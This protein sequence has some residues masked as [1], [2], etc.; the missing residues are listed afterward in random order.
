MNSG[1]LLINKPKDKTSFY[2]VHVLRKLTGV[3]KIGHAG[4]LDPLA[5]GVMVMLIGSTYTRQTPQFI[6]HTKEYETTLLLGKTSDTYDAQGVI[7]DHS[8]YI[9]SL[10]EVET[11]ILS[12]QGTV[13]QIPP[14]FSAKKTKRAKALRF[15][16]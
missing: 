16:P 12:F 10:A 8:S 14:M 7:T 2:L 3:K 5:T 6:Q 4:T 13:K 9:P 15:S 1:I 11:A